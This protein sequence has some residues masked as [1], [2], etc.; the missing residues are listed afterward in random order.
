ML[1]RMRR[2]S[3]RRGFTLVEAIVSIAVFAIAAVMFAMILFTA[4]NM[5]NMSLVYDSDRVALMHFIETGVTAEGTHGSITVTG[6]TAEGTHGSI[7]VTAYNHENGNEEQFVIDLNKGK[8]T[9]NV[10]G[11]YVEYKTTGGRRYVIF[12]AAEDKDES[13]SGGGA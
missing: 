1:G 7:T 13:E 6:V 8:L 3:A 10:E 12:L 2:K 4:T 9:Y 5:V 11:E